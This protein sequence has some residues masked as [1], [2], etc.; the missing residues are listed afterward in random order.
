MIHPVDDLSLRLSAMRR[1]YEGEPLD[2]ADLAPSWLDQFVRWL[3]QAVAGGEAEP[4]A[5]ILATS[6]PDGRPSARTVLLKALDA[7]GFVFFTNLR[8]RKGREIADN[9]RAALVFPWLDVRRQV[10]VEGAVE[11]IDPADSDAYFAG[12]P[13]GAQV[14]ALASPQ[15]EVVASREELERRRA[16]AERRLAEGAARPG[17]WGGLRVVPDS[18]EFWQG[19]A[20]RFHDRL[21]YR[22]GPDGAWHVERLAP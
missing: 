14:G 13:Y 1:T 16:E 3:D 21:R 11:E 18:V 22:L 9:P 12:R 2:E 6:T 17:H 8:S 20:D 19:R 4:N 10:V 15:S 5:M 7:R